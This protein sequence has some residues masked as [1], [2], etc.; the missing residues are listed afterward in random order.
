VSIAE[1][2]RRLCRIA[3]HED[4]V[5]VRQVHRE[6]VD[7]ALDAADHTDSF[8]EVRLGMPRR[9]HKRNEHLL[10]PLP[11]A[12]NVVLHDRD[13]AR[14]PVLVAQPFEDPL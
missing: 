11:P 9:M 7:L 10:C 12:G 8:A 3:R 1:R 13:L 4:R 5:G 2:F 6:E 14:K